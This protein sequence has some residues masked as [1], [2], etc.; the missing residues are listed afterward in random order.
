MSKGGEL[1]CDGLVLPAPSFLLPWRRDEY[2]MQYFYVLFF[3]SFYSLLPLTPATSPEGKPPCCC[4]SQ[5]RGPLERPLARP[6][7]DEFQLTGIG[8][9]GRIGSDHVLS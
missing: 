3:K 7:P 9:Y 2:L 6:A 1:S 5:D 8:G 4:R